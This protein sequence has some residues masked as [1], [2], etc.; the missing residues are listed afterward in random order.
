MTRPIFNFDDITKEM[1]D[2]KHDLWQ[3]MAE[4]GA[5]PKADGAIGGRIIGTVKWWSHAKGYG[6]LTCDAVPDDV[7]V[8]HSGLIGAGYKNLTEG[9]RVEF[10]LER[11]QRRE[12]WIATGV[13][14]I[15]GR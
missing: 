7:F 3:R 9:E 8:H 11:N 5:Q 13:T 10:S 12:G 1:L 6:F 15:G 14:G 2:E 4:A